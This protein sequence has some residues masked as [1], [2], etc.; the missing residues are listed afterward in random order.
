MSRK[1]FRVDEANALIPVLNEVFQDVR[2]HK[3]TIRDATQRIEVLE[4]LWNTQVRN[5][6]NPDHA[7]F[8]RLHE[9]VDRA[10]RGLQR[11]VEEGV[12]G[13]GLRFPAGGLEHGLVDFPTT[14]QGRWVY[15]CWKVGEREIRYWHEIDSGYPG[16][17]ELSD[18]DRVTMGTDDPDDID[19]SELDFPELP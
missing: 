7:E 4:L 13:R 14:Y 1:A 12:L 3:H 16:R 6:A 19:D 17:R 15:L 9:D 11:C 10:L 2:A 18:S 5:P 8:I